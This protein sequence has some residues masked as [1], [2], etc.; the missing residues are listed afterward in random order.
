MVSYVQDQGQVELRRHCPEHQHGGPYFGHSTDSVIWPLG[1]NELHIYL[2]R[3]PSYL[4]NLTGVTGELVVN[5][6]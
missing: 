2:F 6:S 1:P 3:H 4:F 5:I